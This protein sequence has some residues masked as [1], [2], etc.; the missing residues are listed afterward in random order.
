LYVFG[1]ALGGG[2]LA[3]DKLYE[4]DVSNIVD[5]AVWNVK[6]TRGTTPGVRYGH[7][8]GFIKPYLIVHGG[9]I[10]SESISDV[11]VNDILN[12]CEWRKVE[13]GQE[14]PPPRVYHSV[15]MCKTGTAN[16]MMVIFGG[17]GADGH[18]LNDIWGLRKHKDGRL[19]W[20]RAPYRN[21]GV[22]PA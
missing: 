21:V 6:N 12:S 20:M 18:P 19:D 16:G 11:W 14:N 7:V 8:L 15:S 4:L 17:R 22:R 3:D 2:E 9:N 1:G 13:T 5:K 10:G